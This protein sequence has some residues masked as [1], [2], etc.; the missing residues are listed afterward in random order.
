MGDFKDWSRK[1]DGGWE[2]TFH[3]PP[4]SLRRRWEEEER[5]RREREAKARSRDTSAPEGWYPDPERAGELRWWTGDEWTEW[6]KRIAKP[7]TGLGLALTEYVL[8]WV[9]GVI[10]FAMFVCLLGVLGT[11]ACGG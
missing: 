4:E 6:R 7:S 10:L 11:L 8:V 1:V 2:R 3:G 9:G 5:Q